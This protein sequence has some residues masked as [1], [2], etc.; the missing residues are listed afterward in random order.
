MI[1]WTP[2]LT[3]ATWLARAAWDAPAFAQH[4]CAATLIPI[5]FAPILLAAPVVLPSSPAFAQNSPSPPE[6]KRSEKERPTSYGVEI[7]LSSGHADR[8]IVIS[9][10]P[11]V[12]P[13]TWVSGSAATF[14]AWR[15]VTLAET[16]DSS[17]PQILEM[18]LRVCHEWQEH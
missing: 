8:G 17:R 5:L 14:S 1:S 4:L 15:N 18:E 7:E 13:V 2:N 3:G 6:Q 9:D 11:V 12:Q 10:R 16:T